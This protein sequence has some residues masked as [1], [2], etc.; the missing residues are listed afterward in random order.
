MVTKLDSLSPETTQLGLNESMD[1]FKFYEGA[2]DAAKE[3][4]WSITT[5]TLAL[6]AGILAFSF[7]FFAEHAGSRAFVDIE[8][9][10]AVVGTA[11]CG[12][13]IYM[14]HEFGGHIAHHWESSN[15][16]A[17][18][19]RRLEPFIGTKEANKVRADGSRYK[20]PFPPF[21][22]RLQ[23]LAVGFAFVHVVTA[24]LLIESA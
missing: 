9:A 12:F 11:L 19:D 7:D 20:V 24:F 10:C 21:C 14:L 5:W 17:A 8:S 16:I 18:A 1:L 22:R 15:R 3:R 2:A 6:N 4:S 13:L 23:Y